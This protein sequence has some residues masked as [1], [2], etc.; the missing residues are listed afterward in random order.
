[1]ICFACLK[2]TNLKWFVKRWR[3]RCRYAQSLGLSEDLGGE[4]VPGKFQGNGGL[5]SAKLWD[6]TGFNIYDQRA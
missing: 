1:N 4:A 5:A 3:K 6:I 2:L